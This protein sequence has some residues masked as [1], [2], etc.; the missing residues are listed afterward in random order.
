MYKK[1]KKL[2]E[3]EEDLEKTRAIKD[4]G[5]KA[6]KEDI[7]EED[8]GYDLDDSGMIP[9]LEELKAVGKDETEEGIRNLLEEDFLEETD[10]YNE[11][12]DE[13]KTK[14]YD[15]DSDFFEEDFLEENEYEKELDDLED[16]EQS[17][18]PLGDDYLD[19][20]YMEENDQLLDKKKLFKEDDFLDDGM[21][22]LSDLKVKFYDEEDDDSNINDSLTRIADALERIADSLENK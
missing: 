13:N 17:E 20:G 1:D 19:D 14:G 6:M 18:I 2:L 11:F 9:K 5:K 21:D 4:I 7:D 8:F 16:Y 3:F 12:E 22:E 10:I 15:L